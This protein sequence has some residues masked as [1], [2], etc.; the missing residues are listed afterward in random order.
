MLKKPTIT[1]LKIGVVVRKGVIPPENFHIPVN[2][3]LVL[4]LSAVWK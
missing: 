4:V 1:N 2:V 3:A